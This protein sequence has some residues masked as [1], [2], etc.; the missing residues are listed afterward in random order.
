MGEMTPV[1]LLANHKHGEDGEEYRS[2]SKGTERSQEK[3]HRLF[4]LVVEQERDWLIEKEKRHH[5]HREHE[6]REHEHRLEDTGVV[7]RI[8]PLERPK[9]HERHE[10]NDVR[11]SG[12]GIVERVGGHAGSIT[13][14]GFR[15]YHSSI[16]RF[17]F[18]NS[19]DSRRAPA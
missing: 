14:H 18:Q 16:R 8:R 5:C 7:C 3:L 6:E 15:G 11:D 9:K 10:H 17:E 13:L 1:T 12:Q 4:A 2:R 19:V